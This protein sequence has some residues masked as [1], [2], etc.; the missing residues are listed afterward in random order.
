[1]KRDTDDQGQEIHVPVYAS[2]H[3]FRRSFGE[4]WAALNMPPQLM[5]L[6]RHESIETT[7]RFYVGQNARKTSAILWDARKKT[8]LDSADN[9]ADTYEK[10]HFSKLKSAENA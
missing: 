4:R 9:S 10:R 2:Y 1:M 5:E 8:N 7:L 3:D 6:M